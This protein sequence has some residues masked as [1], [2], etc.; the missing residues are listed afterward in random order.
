MC[1]NGAVC[2]ANCNCYSANDCIGPQVIGTDASFFPGC[3]NGIRFSASSIPGGTFHT[4]LVSRKP[5]TAPNDLLFFF[6]G[7]EDDP[8][9]DL[10]GF[11]RTE[12]EL[13]SFNPGGGEDIYV[14]TTLDRGDDV[15]EQCQ[16]SN[17]GLPIRECPTSY[18]RFFDI[19]GDGDGQFD[20]M[21]VVFIDGT[22]VPL[23]FRMLFVPVLWA[24][25]QA[26]FDMAAQTQANLFANATAL[27]AC[28][29]TIEIVT[30]NVMTQN[31]NTFTCN[32]NDCMVDSLPGF[33]RGLGLGASSFDLIVGLMPNGASPCT[34]IVG[35]SNGMDTVWLEATGAS[36]LAHEIGHIYDLAD[37][38]C[39]E[40][41]G[42][43]R[44]CAGPGDFNFLGADLGCSP[45]TGGGCCACGTGA[46]GAL[47]CQ[48]AC[49]PNM[50]QSN[51][52]GC[53]Q[54]NQG[55][56][57]GQCIMSARGVAGATFC[58]RCLNRLNGRTEIGC[59]AL[60]SAAFRSII[61][62][63]LSVSEMGEVLLNAV[64]MGQGRGTRIDPPGNR[65]Q[66]MLDGPTGN[67]L[68]EQFDI[69][70]YDAPFPRE[71]VN[72]RY[73]APVDFPTDDPP[74]I[75]LTVMDS[76][77]TVFRGTLFGTAPHADAG[78]DVSGECASPDGAV[79]K[80]DG[81]ASSDPDD[82]MLHFSWFAPG[83]VFDDVTSA[84][85]SAQFPLGATN[86]TLVVNDGVFDSDPD[87]TTPTVVD[88]TAPAI[89]LNGP[90]ALSLECNV[91]TY[92]E[93]GASASDI[94]DNTLTAA[95]IGGDTVDVTTVGVYT[96]N[97]D[98][99]DASGNAAAQVARTVTVLDS[100]APVIKSLTASPNRLWP[101][102]H[103]MVPVA[104]SA[105][106]SDVCDSATVC[107]IL[108]VRSN[109]PVNAPG[110]GNT[111]P[112]WEITGDL[113]VHLRAERSGTGIG[114]VYTITVK[115][116]DAS[117]N[118]SMATVDVVAP[119]NQ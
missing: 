119:H 116:A 51:Y 77:D 110:D 93:L 16:Q 87:T 113:T 75:I 69:I 46:M 37:E 80:L 54:G 103:K 89:T 56:G 20:D 102:N 72:I 3:I 114:R 118:S 31:F 24:G 29:N 34:P 60:P 117:G 111:T 76:G 82:D 83:I 14:F 47:A 41:A 7:A 45:L 40:Q 94:C 28:T 44:R 35:C 11:M 88:T 17:G 85:P 104:V 96:V 33:V 97:Y 38:Y 22:A 59:D 105:D 26:Q 84:M 5:A 10:F 32:A 52:H 92:T 30:L 48:A 79:L 27:A 108:S 15:G 101:P 25:T 98:A 49:D 64:E 9:V 66:I 42:G 78:N 67:L 2:R 100:S 70:Q 73:K 36:V 6:G 112:D 95:T 53:C 81:S 39:S 50:P 90:A 109:E 21:E 43:D 65:F 8:G 55:T 19:D 107:R 13:R 57:G 62:V 99:V 61:A 12:G 58:Q 1:P 71:R 63:D 68:N 91:D 4:F 74:P 106:V 23:N 86:V 115:C 18:G